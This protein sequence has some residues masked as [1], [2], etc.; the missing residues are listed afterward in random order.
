MKTIAIGGRLRLRTPSAAAGKA[1]NTMSCVPRC[2]CSTR[3]GVVS[4]VSSSASAG[5]SARS[6]SIHGISHECST[7]SMAPMRSDTAS[8][9]PDPISAF[10]SRCSSSSRWA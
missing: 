10:T 2:T 6:F 4:T 3:M 1:A 9:A 7:D 5:C 8:G